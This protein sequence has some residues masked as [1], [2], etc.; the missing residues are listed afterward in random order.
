[1]SSSADGP[2]LDLRRLV[3][4]LDRHQV[5]YLLCGGAAATATAYGA[6]RLSEDAD[7]VVRRE[8]AN[9]DRLAGALREL[10]GRL[11]VAGMSD[12]EAKR[13]PVQIDARTLC[14]LSITTWMTAAGP[15]DVLA[16]LQAADGRLVPYEEL[17]ERATVLQAAG[18]VVRAA[19]LDDIIVAKERANRLKDQDAL[20]ALRA[21][22]E[23]GGLTE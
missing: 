15:L 20:P 17:A 19:S 18:S 4:S 13:L 10:N 23:A 16:G 22:R 8:R 7:C 5:E 2:A 1:M 21:L 14:D 12:E 6:R 11:R 9:L 3:A